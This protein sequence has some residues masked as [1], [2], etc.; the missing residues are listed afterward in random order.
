[1]KAQNHQP[2]PKS[3]LADKDKTEVFASVSPVW[4]EWRDAF[5]TFDWA[6]EYSNAQ[7]HLKQISNLLTLAK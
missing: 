4:L 5:R 6:G 2:K 7:Y 3:T 1:M